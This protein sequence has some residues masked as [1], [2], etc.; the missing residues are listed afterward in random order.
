M[1][2]NA[3]QITFG[4]GFGTGIRTVN[5]THC[6]DCVIL[7]LGR[8]FKPNIKIWMRYIRSEFI[9]EYRVFALLLRLRSVFV[10]VISRRHRHS[11]FRVFRRPKLNRIWQSRQR[12]TECDGSQESTHGTA[13]TAIE[14]AQCGCFQCWKL[15]TDQHLSKICR[16]PN[17]SRWTAMSHRPQIPTN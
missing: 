7:D 9:A 3:R 15:L 12:Q 17:T 2:G 11:K 1:R 8:G 14:T 16:Y 6:E 4:F 10:V 13:L 5:A